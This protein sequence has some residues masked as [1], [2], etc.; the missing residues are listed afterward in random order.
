MPEERYPDMIKD[1]QKRCPE[2][3]ADSY[4]HIASELGISE[5]TVSESVKILEK[6]QLIV[7]KEAYHIKSEECD[8]VTPYTMFANFEK[9]ENK[10]LLD[11]GLRYAY[12]EMERKAKQIDK[13]S[14][15][16][17]KLKNI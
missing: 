14:V 8:Y 7:Y 15:K 9:R 10:Y 11:S 17:Y 5:R 1:R 13:N 16:G 4:K 6:F 12:S 3:Y 2:A